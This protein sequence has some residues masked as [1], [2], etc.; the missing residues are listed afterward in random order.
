MQ[1]MTS[2]KTIEDML[3]QCI[4]QLYSITDDGACDEVDLTK[5]VTR[6]GKLVEVMVPVDR[7]EGYLTAIQKGAVLT[8]EERTIIPRLAH[9]FPGPTLSAAAR[10]VATVAEELRDDWMLGRLPRG[11]DALDDKSVSVQALAANSNEDTEQAKF[12]KQGEAPPLVKWLIWTRSMF[13]Q[14]PAWAT[15]ASV[16]VVV[17][18]IAAAIQWARHEKSTT[19]L[20][21]DCFATLPREAKELSKEELQLLKGVVP[22]TAFVIDRH[23]EKDSEDRLRVAKSL[24]TRGLY[25]VNPKDEPEEFKKYE[26]LVTPTDL[27]NVVNQALKDCPI[28]TTINSGERR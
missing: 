25:T 9:V 21:P 4:S 13:R 17:P 3:S 27:G 5:A 18:I 19:D 1:G 26:Y 12:E 7:R 6:L 15:L 28:P 2:T 24:E 10:R 11:N 8:D 16:V 23:L 22:H 20:R 14:H